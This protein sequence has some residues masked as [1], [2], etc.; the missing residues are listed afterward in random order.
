M[1]SLPA[2]ISR[3]QI[4]LHSRFVTTSYVAERLMLP[5]FVAMSLLPRVLH[6]LITTLMIVVLLVFGVMDSVPSL[7]RAPD[8]SAP[9]QCICALQLVQQVGLDG[10]HDISNEPSDQ[11]QLLHVAAGRRQPGLDYRDAISYQ[12]VFWPRLTAPSLLRP[13]NF[14]V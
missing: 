6:R 9:E 11:E 12:V 1:S 10:L 2:G 8:Q 7:T 5:D 13:P 3:T 14:T 4:G